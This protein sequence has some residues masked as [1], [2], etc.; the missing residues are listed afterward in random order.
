[1]LRH[2]LAVSPIDDLARGRFQL[3]IG[4]IDPLPGDA[5][6]RIVFCS[7][8]VYYDL[9]E[10]RRADQLEH[11]VLVRLEQ[12]YPF[13]IHEY[14]AVINRYPNAA[15]VVWCQ[16]EP[17]NQG[18]WYQIRHRLQEALTG[19]TL[20]YAGRAGAAAPATGI[21][22]LHVEQQRALVYAALQGAMITGDGS[23][24]ARLT[25]K[26]SAPTKAKSVRKS[27]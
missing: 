27:V 25:T 26:P 13:P 22:E 2:K 15:T 3:V 9:L 12:L 1:L 10:Q 19:R 6:T 5:V 18:A 16:E 8:K 14:K 11:V 24:T 17:Q 20:V 7:G 23:P 21:H 4:E